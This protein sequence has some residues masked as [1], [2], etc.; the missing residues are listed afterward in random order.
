MATQELATTDNVI[1]G[2]PM[3]DA[4]EARQIVKNINR[5]LDQ[6]RQELL[7][8]YD[9]EGWRALGY[10]SWRACVKNEFEGSSTALYR[11]LT[12]A[13]VERELFGDSRIGNPLPASQLE[14]I[15]KAAPA[16]R[17]KVIARADQIAGDTPRTAKHIQQAVTEIATPDLPPEFAIVQRRL[18]VHGI[19]LSTHAHGDTVAF[20][21][22]KGEMTGIVTREWSNVLDRLSLLEDG[23]D[24]PPIKAAPAKAPIAQVARPPAVP[25]R[26]RRPVSAD[27]SAQVAYT[28]QLEAYASALEAFIME[29]QRRMQ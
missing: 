9:R 6:S 13:K 18:L 4:T 25:P 21:T 12:A 24:L 14:T 22:K 7:E 5:R 2:V 15:A 3:M 8:L 28:T 10:G 27:V 26:P 11:Q 19:T 29:L 23:M 1:V 20:V 17:P 16:D